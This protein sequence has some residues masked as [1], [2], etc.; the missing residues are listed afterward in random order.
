M[1]VADTSGIDRWLNYLWERGATDL[2]LTENSP[3]LV[4]IDGVLYVI[5]GEPVLEA[6]VIEDATLRTMRPDIRKSFEETWEV[7]FSFGW[8]D[9]ARFR[10]NAFRQKGGVA[11]AL[12]LIPQ[13]IPTVHDLGLPPVIETFLRKPHGL[14]LVTGPTGSGKSTSLAAMINYLNENRACHILTIEDP[15]EYTHQHK[16]AAVNQRELGVDTHSFGNAMR[17]ALREDPDVLLVG[18]MRDLETIKLALTIA[19]TGHLVFATLHTND[20]SQTVDRIVDVFPPEQQEQIRVQLSGVL[21]GIISQRLIP[22]IG[23]GRV[24][25]FEVLTGTTGIKNLIREGKTRMIRNVVG[26]GQKDGMQ[27]IEHS[28]GDL[29]NAGL[30]SHEDAIAVSLYPEEIKTG[31]SAQAV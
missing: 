7:D 20:T 14:V 25:A 27:L 5:E 22:R 2:L 19:E 21:L 6:D 26:T 16:R 4:R 11:F 31:L 12:R 18:E 30:I 28:L 29:I 1:E 9:L 24:A 23:G 10:A 3:P 17:S 15:I 8:H 13:A